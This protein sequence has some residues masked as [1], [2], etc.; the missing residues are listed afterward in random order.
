MM[1]LKRHLLSDEI[2]VVLII[3]IDLLLEFGK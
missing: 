2:A 3:E 1:V